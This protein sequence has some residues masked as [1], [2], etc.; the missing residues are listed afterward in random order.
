MKPPVFPTLGTLGD[1]REGLLD[2]GQKL[3]PLLPLKSAVISLRQRFYLK[4]TGCLFSFYVRVL[5]AQS[6]QVQLKCLSLTPL[7]RHPDKLKFWH[8]NPSFQGGIYSRCRFWDLR[9]DNIV[10]QNK[11][12]SNIEIY[13]LPVISIL[14]NLRHFLSI[15]SFDFQIRLRYWQLKL[16]I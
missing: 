2:E 12:K 1:G 13:C 6:H 9:L 5:S 15:G 4:E 3:P 8:F 11:K 16:I 14:K 7:V 10:R